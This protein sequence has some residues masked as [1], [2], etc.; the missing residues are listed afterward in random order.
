VLSRKVSKFPITFTL[1]ISPD[2]PPQPVSRVL[3]D[4]HRSRSE[5]VS[6]VPP[7]LHCVRTIIT[8]SLFIRFECM[9]NDKNVEKVNYELGFR[10]L[11]RWYLD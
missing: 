7:L 9:S 3:R 8:S 2:S 5:Y 1:G 10:G 11:L 4:H 6:K